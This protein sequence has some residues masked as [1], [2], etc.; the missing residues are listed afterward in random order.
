MEVLAYG[1]LFLSIKDCENT[2]H[3]KNTPGKDIYPA[4]I[5]PVKIQYLPTQKYP[6]EDTYPG[7]KY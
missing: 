6:H 2:Y 4:K 1:Q 5:L 7:K 3:R